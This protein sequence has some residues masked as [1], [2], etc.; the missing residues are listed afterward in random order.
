[1]SGR[2]KKIE[3]GRRSF[4]KSS[5]LAAAAG[6]AS[7]GKLFAA[8]AEEIRVGVVG[9]GGRGSGATR[10]ALD[11]DPAVKI[12]AMADVFEDRVKSNIDNQ[13]SRFPD[14]VDVPEERQFVG[15]DAYRKLLDLDLTYVIFATPP[16]FRPQMVEAAVQSGKHVFMEKPVAVDPPGCRRIMAAGQVAKSKGLSIVTGTQRHHEAPYL[17]CLERVR[18]GAIGE[19]VGG[20]VYWNQG[21]LWYKDRQPDWNDMAWMIRDWVNWRWLS[22][23]HIV[24]QHVHNIDVANWF[25]GAHPV[26]AVGSGGR[27]HRVTGDQYDYFAVDFEY[28]DGSHVASYARQ[29]NGCANEVAERLIGTKGSTYTMSG[30]TEIKGQNAWKYRRRDR[31]FTDPYVQEHIDLI[32]S[33]RKGEGLNEAQFIAE[34]TLTAI[35]GREAAYTGKSVSWDEMMK[36]N[37][38]LGPEEISWDTPLV[39]VKIPVAGVA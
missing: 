15:F 3:T 7:T 21:Q 9:C 35:M 5:T 6:L 17:E 38:A 33:I 29:V 4:L 20:Q 1:M 16:Y 36:S 30:R 19:I 11:A 24:E 22:G 26:R 8:G 25:K 12:T 13:K 34:S 18:E 37:M 28:A 39:E 23:D 10:N 32:A 2:R 14:R 27:A 31:E